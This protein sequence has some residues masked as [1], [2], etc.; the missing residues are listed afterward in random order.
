M[1]AYFLQYVKDLSHLKICVRSMVT[2]KA[3]CI[4][5]GILEDDSEWVACMEEASSM[6]NALQLRCLFGTIL[7]FCEP[8]CP[9]ILWKRFR[10]EM[11]ED[12][13]Y[14]LSRS[15]GQFIGIEQLAETH[16]LLHL[17]EI[18]RAQ[19]RTLADFEG[20]PELNRTDL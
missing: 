7:L 12:F 10:E 1:F 2:S 9:G 11:I 4:A 15:R 19:R 6:Q 20:M 18:L 8:S 14:Q 16:A 5:R 17:E 3:A 13:L